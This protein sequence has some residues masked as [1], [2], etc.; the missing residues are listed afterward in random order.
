M[1]ERERSSTKRKESTTD[2]YYRANNTNNTVPILS[3]PR[4]EKGTGLLRRLSLGSAAFAK[5]RSPQSVSNYCIVELI[6]L[7]V[8]R[9]HSLSLILL[10]PLANLL[11]FHPTPLWIL[12]LIT[13]CLVSPPNLVVPPLWVPL[14]RD[15][16]G[17]LLLWGNGS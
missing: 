10:L 7:P 12:L 14:P 2:E 13:L 1:N 6:R 5:V 15:R 9:R 16:V 17:R 3:D 4:T 11:P 8:Y